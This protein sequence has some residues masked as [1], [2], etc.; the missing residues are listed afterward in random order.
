MCDEELT[1]AELT[2]IEFYFDIVLFRHVTI[3]PNVW[4]GGGDS[5]REKR[6]YKKKRIGKRKIEKNCF[7]TDST[8]FFP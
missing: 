8:E 2:R 6:N 4:G 5:E 1:C 7:L 3:K